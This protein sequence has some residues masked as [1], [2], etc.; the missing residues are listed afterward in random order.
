MFSIQ[1]TTSPNFPVNYLV[2]RKK[3]Y[4]FR[5]HILTLYKQTVSSNKSTATYIQNWI[6]FGQDKGVGFSWGK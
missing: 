5:W 4:F 1:T 6:Y 3:I 2:I